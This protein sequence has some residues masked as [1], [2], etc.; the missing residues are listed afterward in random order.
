LA[1]AESAFA[2]IDIA[3]EAACDSDREGLAVVSRSW[4]ASYSGTDEDEAVIVG[5]RRSYGEI[6]RLTGLA[7]FDDGL[8]VTDGER[9]HPFGKA[10]L[11]FETRASTA[12]IPG[13]VEP[14]GAHGTARRRGRGL[15]LAR[16]LVR[17]GN[18]GR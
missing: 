15:T 10:L 9:W 11:L 3:R 12:P 18:R 7:P 4:I 5:N 14:V 16:R 2:L 8:T 1:S 17:H 6:A 13:T